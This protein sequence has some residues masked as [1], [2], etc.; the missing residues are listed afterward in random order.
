VDHKIKD[1]IVG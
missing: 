1:S